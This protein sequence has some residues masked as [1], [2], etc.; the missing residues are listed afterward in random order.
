METPI[1]L[2]RKIC[3]NFEI[4]SNL[5]KVKRKVLMVAYLIIRAL[6]MQA[7]APNE[8]DRVYIFFVPTHVCLS[9]RHLR[10]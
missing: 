1:L 7:Y 10:F 5:T 6:A 4:Q 9:I 2:K 8:G 3:T